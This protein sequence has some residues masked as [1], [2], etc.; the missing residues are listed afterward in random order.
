MQ[1]IKLNR[2]KAMTRQ[3][4]ESMSALFAMAPHRGEKQSRTTAITARSESHM[5]AI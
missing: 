1:A 4:S 5:S 2:E 3:V